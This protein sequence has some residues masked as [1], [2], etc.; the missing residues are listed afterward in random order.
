MLKNST[1]KDLQEK[2]FV[3]CVQEKTYVKIGAFHVNPKDFIDLRNVPIRIYNYGI[4]GHYAN[5]IIVD[6]NYDQKDDE[7]E[8]LGISHI[9]PW[10]NLVTFI[11]TSEQIEFSGINPVKLKS[12]IKEN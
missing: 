11:M 6:L 12:M 8:C 5:R 2:H 3:E 1:N 7:L 9:E 10:A 4:N